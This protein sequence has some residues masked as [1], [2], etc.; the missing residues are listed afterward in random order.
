VSKQGLNAGWGEELTTARDYPLRSRTRGGFVGAAD[1]EVRR[2]EVTN[3][4]WP[5]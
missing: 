1:H 3:E 2:G 4:G 5:L